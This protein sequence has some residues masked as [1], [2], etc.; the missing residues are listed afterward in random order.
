MVWGAARG[1]GV[2]EIGNDYVMDMGFLSRDDD[3]VQ[4]VDS[5]DG[6]HN[7][8]NTLKTTELYT[9][10]WLKWWTSCQF[11]KE[12]IVEVGEHECRWSGYMV[13][14]VRQEGNDGG[15]D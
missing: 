12:W 9:L 15:L 6:L 4:E 1:W 14:A 10:K 8:G 13:I 3:N 5:G 11:E 2:K 7:I